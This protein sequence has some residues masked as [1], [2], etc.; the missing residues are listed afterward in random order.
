MAEDLEEFG[1]KRN[2]CCNDGDCCHGLEGG[3]IL[4][5]P[6]MHEIPGD[7]EPAN[8]TDDVYENILGGREVL[9]GNPMNR[10]PMWVPDEI[11]QRE[12]RGKEEHCETRQEETASWFHGRRDRCNA[13]GIMPHPEIMAESD[14]CRQLAKTANDFVQVLAR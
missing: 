11:I 14:G 13:T 5:H 8:I 9:K 10:F 7:H 6:V 2:A 12:K 3:R 4:T 1:R